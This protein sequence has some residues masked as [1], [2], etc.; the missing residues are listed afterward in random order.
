MCSRLDGC[1]QWTGSMRIEEERN[2][3]QDEKPDNKRR[4]DNHYEAYTNLSHWLQNCTVQQVFRE[5]LGALMYVGTGPDIA[6][7]VNYLSQFNNN[8]EK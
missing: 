1:I 6:Y 2:L 3:F 8:Y 4:M 7:A 5:L